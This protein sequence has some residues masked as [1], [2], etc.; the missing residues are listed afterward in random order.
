MGLHPKVTKTREIAVIC[1]LLFMQCL[2]V[3]KNFTYYF[4]FLVVMKLPVVTQKCPGSCQ[5]P[6]ITCMRRIFCE[7]NRFSVVL[8]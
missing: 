3:C 8:Y 7:Q 4:V 5:R 6:D 2:Y 1:R